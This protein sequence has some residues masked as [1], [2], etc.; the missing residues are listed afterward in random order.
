AFVYDEAGQLLGEYVHD[1]SNPNSQSGEYIWLPRPDGGSELVGYVKSQGNNSQRYAV[2]SD[3]LGTPRRITNESGQPVWQW[4]YSA[5]GDNAAQV[6]AAA[7][8]GFAFNPRF[9]GQYFDSESGKHYNYF[10]TYDPTTGR[11]TQSDPIGLGGGWNRFAYVGGNPLSF[12]DYY[13][14]DKTVWRFP[15]GPTNGNWG[16]RCWSGGQYSC[17]DKGMGSLPPTDSADACYKNH[18]IC[19]N[20]CPSQNDMS[21]RAACNKKLVNELLALPGDPRQWPIPPIKGAERDSVNFRNRAT[22]YYGGGI[23]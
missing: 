21:C 6:L 23:Q 15:S 11:Y 13:G 17:G 14:L 18:D 3:H 8:P 10:R 22:G 19:Y 1:G 20:A 9:P 12:A 2:H 7:E 4:A 5:Y 16:G